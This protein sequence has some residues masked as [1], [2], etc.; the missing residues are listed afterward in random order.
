VRWRFSD[1]FIVVFGSPRKA[2]RVARRG[3]MT[4]MRWRRA[5]SVAGWVVA[6]ENPAM[7]ATILLD[8]TRSRLYK[9][10]MKTLT[11]TNARK[12]LGRWL[13][14]AGRGENIGI[15]CGADI[16]ALRKVEVEA[17]DEHAYAMREYGVT[18][19]ELDQFG[20]AVDEHIAQERRAG[21]VTKTTPEQLRSQIDQAAH[22]HRRRSTTPR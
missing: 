19:K 11:I 13:S 10:S 2:L 9:V 16:I 12:N 1:G 3:W 18:R 8:E 15:I 21:R 4:R 22:H 5:M 6:V 20:K 14:A 17:V 7:N